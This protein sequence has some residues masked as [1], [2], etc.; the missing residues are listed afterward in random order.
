LSRVPLTSPG[1][2]PCVA[3]HSV[4]K[5]LKALPPTCFIRLPSPPHT[6]HRRVSSPLRHVPTFPICFPPAVLWFAAFPCRQESTRYRFQPLTTLFSQEW[7]PWSGC[8][9]LTLRSPT[10]TSS[11]NEQ[12]PDR[13][14][15]PPPS[16]KLVPFIGH[17]T[18]SV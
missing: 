3:K 6:F 2:L 7:A 14:P 4:S 1:P 17:I 11:G 18:S 16:L 9:P 10:P 13:L 5:P 8:S 12:T 15:K